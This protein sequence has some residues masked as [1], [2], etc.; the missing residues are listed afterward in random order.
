MLEEFSSLILNRA[1]CSASEVE[2]GAIVRQML[3]IFLSSTSDLN[4]ERRAIKEELPQNTYFLYD[5]TEDRARRA[6]P[7]EHCRKEIENSEVFVALMGSQ[8]GSEFPSDPGKRSI[9]EWEFD[10]AISLKDLEVL[11][12]VKHAAEMA[13]R[14]ERQQQFIERLSSFECGSWTHFFSSSTQLAQWLHLSLERFLAEYMEEHKA[15]AR[16]RMITLHKFQFLLLVIVI[17]GILVTPFLNL[18]RNSV[19]GLTFT[20]MVIITAGAVLLKLFG[21]GADE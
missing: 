6:S 2:K 1:I 14:E 9:C 18:P 17:V 7:Y 13:P 20:V 16:E 15:R 21:G 11:P 4:P 8:Y 5:S 10:T 3:Q 12:F 19:I